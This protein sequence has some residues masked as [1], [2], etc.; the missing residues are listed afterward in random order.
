MIS[1]GMEWVL[2][3]PIW[4]KRPILTRDRQEML[5][6][7]KLHTRMRITERIHST[8][9]NFHCFGSPVLKDHRPLRLSIPLLCRAARH[10][11]KFQMLW[12]HNTARK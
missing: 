12:G 11:I 6:L 8:L 4:E 9:R 10:K 1:E 3:S 7:F 5:F 2:P